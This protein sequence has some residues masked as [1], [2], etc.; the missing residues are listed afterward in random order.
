VFSWPRICTCWPYHMGTSHILH[1]S[2]SL[3][4]KKW[5][6]QSQMLS[7]FCYLGLWPCSSF[8]ALMDLN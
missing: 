6:L 4:L 2:F 3:Y 1:L 7:R 8:I 5:L